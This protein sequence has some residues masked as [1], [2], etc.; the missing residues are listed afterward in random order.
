M[1]YNQARKINISLLVL[2]FILTYLLPL[3]SRLLWQPDETRYAEISREMLQSGNWIVPYMLDIRYFEKPVAGYWMN[4]ISQIVFGHTNFAVRFSSVFCMVLSVLVIYRIAKK[5]W[6][7]SHVAYVASFIYMSMFLVFSVGTYNVLDSMLSLWIA[8]SMYSC[9]LAMKARGIKEKLSTWGSVGFACGMAFMTK[10]FCALVIPVIVMLPVT[11]YQKRFIEMLKYGPVAI[12]CA[13]FIS[14]PWVLAVAQQEPDYWSY[15]FWIEHIKRFV[16][17]DAQHV[18]PFWYYIPIIFLGSIP[19][20][21]LLPGALFKNLKECKSNENMFFL[22]S[23]FILPIFFFSISRGKLPTYMLPC[24]SPLALIIAKYGVDCDCNGKMKV[25]KINSII[26][27]TIGVLAIIAMIIFGLVIQKP[28]YERDELSKI[29]LGVFVFCIWVIVSYLCTL[30]NAKY[31]LWVAFCSLPVSLCVGSIVPNN[32]VNSKLPQ[33]FINQHHHL[34]INSRYLMA[35]NVG[36]ATAL[37]WEAQN[38]NIYLYNTTG[39][40]AYGLEYLD[41]QYRLVRSEQ[42]I[43]WLRKVRK[44]GQVLVFFLLRYKT[45]LPN[46]PKPDE[47]I[48]NSRM[49][50]AVYHQQ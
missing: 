11:L 21:G 29:A 2:F 16:S 32:T 1:L 33:H 35:N 23:W 19:W 46:I 36:I 38:S 30:L 22:M 14:F 45:D 25:L 31:W 48:S 42:F 3:N 37:A 39:E 47:I 50:I 26:N 27:L 8:V 40:L 43:T 49:V 34:L 10:G 28:L 20:V 24:M 6:N 17:D 4:N 12:I 18:A 44:K 15:F 41:S 13:M 5:M 9:I 7:N